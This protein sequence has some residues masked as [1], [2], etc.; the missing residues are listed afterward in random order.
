MHQRIPIVKGFSADAAEH[1]GEKGRLEIESELLKGRGFGRAVSFGFMACLKACPPDP[2]KDQ[3]KLLDIEVLHIQRILF[4]EFP[5]RFY[6]FA[7]QSCE[8]GFAFGNVF[9]FD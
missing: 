4:D 1:D 7:H 2:S 3:K 5:A 6:V 8:D 9:E